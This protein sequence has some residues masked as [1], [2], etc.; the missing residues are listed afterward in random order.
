MERERGQA[1]E[2]GTKI[3]KQGEDLRVVLNAQHASFLS[4]FHAFVL[5]GVFFCSVAV[6]S[7]PFLPSSS[8]RHA[9]P[10]SSL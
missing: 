9:L 1:K 8:P 2:N 6:G 10:M 3:F 4:S 7:V 5:F